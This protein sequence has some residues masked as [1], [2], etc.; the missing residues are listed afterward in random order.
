MAG[1]Y[2]GSNQVYQAYFG[3]NSTL[4]TYA[5]SIAIEWILV[6]GGGAGGAYTNLNGGGGGAGRFMAATSY[7]KKEES[8]SVSSIGVNGFGIPNDKGQSGGNSVVV[9]DSVTYTAPGGGGG[10]RGLISDPVSPGQL[11][12]NGGSGG[13][14]GKTSTSTSI[15]GTAVAGTPS[16]LPNNGYQLGNNGETGTTTSAGRGGGANGLG[17]DGGIVWLDGISYC[18]GGEINGVNAT[19]YGSG[20]GGGIVS[21]QYAN[22]FQGIFKLRY[23]GSPIGTGGTITESGGYTYHTFTTT[24]TFTYTG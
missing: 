11:G 8:I 12:V 24:G 9:I 1:I 2:L 15:G 10:G 20:G 4:P 16:I 18:K 22:G 23:S 19:L 13:G 5:D 3:N 6:G 17:D 7:M 14:G 21:S